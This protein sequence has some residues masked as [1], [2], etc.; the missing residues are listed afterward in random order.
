MRKNVI[1]YGTLMIT[2]IFFYFIT[3]LVLEYI[4]LFWASYTSGPRMFINGLL[5]FMMFV[6][7][8]II[9]QKISE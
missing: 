5:V 3:H 8:L 2:I 7:S 1:F 4:P 6:V 9:A